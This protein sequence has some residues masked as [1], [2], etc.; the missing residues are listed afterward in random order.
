MAL[1]EVL[2]ALQVTASTVKALEEKGFIEISEIEVYR[3]PYQG[4][5]F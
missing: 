1:K 2:S 3:D 4:R 5:D